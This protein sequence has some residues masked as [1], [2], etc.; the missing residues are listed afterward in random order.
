MMK[1][2]VVGW[3]DAADTLDNSGKIQV[4]TTHRIHDSIILTIRIV[5]VFLNFPSF[6]VQPEIVVVIKILFSYISD[7]KRELQPDV[8]GPIAGKLCNIFDEL[9]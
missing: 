9:Q 1:Q 3:H 7:H 2:T 5:R 8:C 6:A 4:H